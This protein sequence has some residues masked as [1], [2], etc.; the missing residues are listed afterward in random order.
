MTTSWNGTGSPP[1]SFE[2]W[3]E[4]S[5]IFTALRAEEPW[6]ITSSIFAPRNMRARCSPSTQRTASETFD[7]PQPFG[8]TTA[9]T[10]VLKSI[11]VSSANDLNPCN[12]S[13]VN[14][15]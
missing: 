14:R 13:F 12:S 2:K 7:L 10:P 4:T 11:S 15:T 8:P 3:S 9:V 6:K 1:S 5:A